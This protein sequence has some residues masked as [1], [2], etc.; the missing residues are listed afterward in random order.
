MPVR[1][2]ISLLVHQSFYLWLHPGSER[3][4][5]RV[6]SSSFDSLPVP[7]VG[8]LCT[9][10][11][12]QAWVERLAWAT[13]ERGILYSHQTTWTKILGTACGQME[14]SCGILTN[15]C[16]K[17]LDKR[18]ILGWC[19]QGGLPGENGQCCVDS[20]LGISKGE[21]IPSRDKKQQGQ[22]RKSWVEQHDFLR[23]Q[24]LSYS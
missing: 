19:S 23:D 9:I 1:K 20:H 3:Q 11:K 21:S 22:K 10:I 7:T 8:Q 12:Q 24:K 14:I 18:D 17:N 16:K 2:V 5:L 4:K 15:L 6:E 13:V